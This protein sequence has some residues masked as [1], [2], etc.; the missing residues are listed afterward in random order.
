MRAI[1]ALLTRQ[2]DLSVLAWRV[3]LAPRA[4][5]CCPSNACV[6]A[7]TFSC[8]ATWSVQELHRVSSQLMLCCPPCPHP[9]PCMLTALRR[10]LPAHHVLCAHAG[11]P[12]A[13]LP[14]HGGLRES[15][16]EAAA[17]TDVQQGQE[18]TAPE[19]RV[20]KSELSGRKQACARFRRWQ[21]PLC[22]RRLASWY[23]HFASG[24]C[25]N[26]RGCRRREA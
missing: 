23:C 21:D 20:L 3:V 18:R 15:C 8:Q 12:R 24:G 2:Q 16:A 1:A 6:C 25:W 9:L 14:A 11:R 19:V 10:L 5:E 17:A 13:A 26:V 4:L 7:F 22:R